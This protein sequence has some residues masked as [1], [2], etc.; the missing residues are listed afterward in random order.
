VLARSLVTWHATQRRIATL[1]EVARRFHRAPST[2]HESMK[3]HQRDN[4]ELFDLSTL[5]DMAGPIVVI[6]A[7]DR[8]TA[9]LPSSP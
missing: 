3:A 7:A 8:Y 5:H 6:A 1:T 2:L 9:T 4:S